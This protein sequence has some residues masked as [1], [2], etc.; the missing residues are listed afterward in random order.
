MKNILIIITALFV[1]GC[2]IQ[3]SFDSNKNEEE[4]RAIET[5]Q[6]LGYSNLKKTNE[7]PNKY[8]GI[9]VATGLVYEGRV[10]RINPPR[11]VGRVY[12]GSFQMVE[13][14]EV[15]FDYIFEGIFRD[16]SKAIIG[17]GERGSHAFSDYEGDRFLMGFPNHSEKDKVIFVY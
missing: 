1:A 11:I 10:S 15:V 14:Q 2:G 3:I 13:Q 7:I 12:S 4:T 16:G 6:N 5:L 9:M 17:Y 8:R